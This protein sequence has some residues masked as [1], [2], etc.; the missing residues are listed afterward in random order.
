M[1][2]ASFQPGERDAK[3]RF[4]QVR[5]GVKTNFNFRPGVRAGVTQSFLDIHG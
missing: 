2:T 5:A 4:D 3:P 1:P